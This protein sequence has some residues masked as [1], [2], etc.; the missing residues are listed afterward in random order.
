[1]RHRT[2]APFAEL[3]APA[4]DSDRVLVSPTHHWLHHVPRDLHPKQLCRYYP[5]VAN[6][7]AAGWHDRI[8]VDRLLVDL[9]FDRRGGRAGFPARILDEL[10]ALAAFNARQRLA[11]RRKCVAE[12]ARFHGRMALPMRLAEQTQG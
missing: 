6:K 1:M 5:R 12:I 2:R 3:R 4:V 10:R 7:I 9:I 8:L 11:D